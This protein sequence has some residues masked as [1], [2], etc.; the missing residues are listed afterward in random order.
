MNII[1]EV[2]N[3]SKSFSRNRITANK[4]VGFQLNEGETHAVVG[5]NGS[6]KSTT[7][8]ILSGLLKP[9]SGRIFFRSREVSFNSPKEA[10][11]LGIGMIHQVPAI[12]PGY[13]SLDN[14]I[15]G[16]EKMNIY[17]INRKR[18]TC[19]IEEIKNRFGIKL[20]LK[21]PPLSPAAKQY[22]LLLSIL[23]RNC[24]V[25]IFDEPAVSFTDIETAEF[26]QIIK[27][28]KNHGITI[29][30]VTHKINAA[31]AMADRI[32]V[33]R[34]GESTSP[35]KTSE[36]DAETV[37]SMVIGQEK[38]KS[39]LY[40]KDAESSRKAGKTVLEVQ[41][42]VIS[43]HEP[44]K[45]S[46][47]IKSG[48][49][50]SF[51]G[52]RDN[53]LDLLEDLLGGFKK[54]VKGKINF[55][56]CDITGLEIRKLRKKGVVYIPSDRIGRGTSLTA[57]VESNIALS[58][59]SDFSPR[60]FISRKKLESFF[61]RGRSSYKIDAHYGQ[62]LWQLSGG[63]I[64]KVVLFRELNK[65]EKILIICEPAWNLD[66]ASR[67]MIYDQ[68]FRLRDKGISIVVIST[69]IEEVVRL[70]DRVMVMHNGGTAGLLEG[71]SIT[72]RNIGRLMLGLE[73]KRKEKSCQGY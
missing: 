62:P 10:L 44:E 48:E 33:F 52:I 21:Q 31:V 64:Q 56:G 63:N 16:C 72:S 60:G 49:I 46:F 47:K 28:L 68:L 26:F 40:G 7:M 35:L 43:G 38:K 37:A 55:E 3:I 69:D 19:E 65:A 2:K 71:E 24:S 58:H 53:N 32:T 6:G 8:H 13:S 29:V 14:M 4:N 57:T 61:N 41:G 42:A 22:T 12:I 1:A 67:D 11:D 51:T 34:K 25:I 73:N 70:S 30:L 17:G 18:H 54:P 5:E 15:I 23:Y 27:K 20:D 66:I 39:L 45:I 9:D 36:T 50:F 59:I